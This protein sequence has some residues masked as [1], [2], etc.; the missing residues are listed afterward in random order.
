MTACVTLVTNICIH[1]CYEEKQAIN[2]AA[3]GP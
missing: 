3:K 2:I 1:G